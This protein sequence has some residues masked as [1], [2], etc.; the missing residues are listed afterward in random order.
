MA[1]ITMAYIVMA[2]IAMANIAM[3]YTVMVYTVMAYIVMALP[4]GGEGVKDAAASAAEGMTSGD[5][6]TLQNRA[7]T[8]CGH[9]YLRP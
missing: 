5:D 3:V 2:Y 6:G 7:T 9:H 8:I 4:D 1:Y